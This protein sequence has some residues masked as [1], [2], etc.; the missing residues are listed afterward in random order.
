MPEELGKTLAASA[1]AALGPGDWIL[2]VS[3]PYVYLT[4]AGSALDPARRA[5]L[6]AAL[7]ATTLRIPGVAAVYDVPK[8]P[9]AC[10]GLADESIDA[11]V[12]RSVAPA[13]RERGALLYVV[14]EPGSFFDPSIVVGKGTS[15]GSPYLYDRTVPLLVR[16]P[17]R[18]EA[19]RVV[20]DATFNVFALTAADL[21]GITPPRGAE[22]GVSLV[23]S[24]VSPTERR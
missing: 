12:C 24:D 2:G 23:S 13:V 14:L 1:R 7:R 6:D 19:G 4:A 10:P 21:L 17:G 5:T 18:V 22:P 11:L 8:V 15:H 9:L 16:A 20:P 3:D